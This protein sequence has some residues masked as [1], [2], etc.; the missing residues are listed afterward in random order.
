MVHGVRRFSGAK[1]FGPV[2]GQRVVVRVFLQMCNLRE[3]MRKAGFDLLFI[4]STA[5][6]DLLSLSCPAFETV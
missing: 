6:P 3:G 1:V 5:I 2:G 4:T